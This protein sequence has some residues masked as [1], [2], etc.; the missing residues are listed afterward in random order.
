[1]FERSKSLY[2]GEGYYCQSLLSGLTREFRV[3]EFPCSL[4]PF[5]LVQCGILFSFY[6]CSYNV[7]YF[8]G[9]IL[10]LLVECGAFLDFGRVRTMWYFGFSFYCDIFSGIDYRTSNTPLK[11][12]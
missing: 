12:N 7:V 1:M 3:W 9:G 4:L 2:P 6:T 8:L 5:N 10:D 11:E